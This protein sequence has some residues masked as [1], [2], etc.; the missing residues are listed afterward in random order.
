MLQFERMAD[1]FAS[2]MAMH[3]MPYPAEVAEA[4]SA[5]VAVLQQVTSDLAAQAGV[6]LKPLLA[7]NMP[8]VPMSCIDLILDF[9]ISS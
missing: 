7:Q 2:C 5:S 6:L 8:G 9:V 1:F 3:C 4:H